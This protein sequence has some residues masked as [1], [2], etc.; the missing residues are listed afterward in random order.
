MVKIA[1]WILVL[2]M[3]VVLAQTARADGG[4]TASLGMGQALGNEFFSKGGLGIVTAQ[5]YV[6]TKSKKNELIV[7]GSDGWTGGDYWHPEIVVLWESRIYSASSLPKGFDL[8]DCILVSFEAEKIRFM[9]FKSGKG[10]FY[11]RLTED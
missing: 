9:D 4:L 6:V 2:L 11:Q 10:G 1:R 3:P 5:L 7:R 8:K